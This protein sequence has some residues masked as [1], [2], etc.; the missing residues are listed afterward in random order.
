[1]LA[2]KKFFSPELTASRHWHYCQVRRGKR[3]NGKG[4]SCRC[5]TILVLVA[6]HSVEPRKVVYLRLGKWPRPA[7]RQLPVLLPDSRPVPSCAPPPP[8]WWSL[9]AQS[10]VPFRLSCFSDCNLCAVAPLQCTTSPR[11]RL[12][13]RRRRRRRRAAPTCRVFLSTAP[14]T[15]A[16]PRAGLQCQPG[17]PCTRTFPTDLGLLWLL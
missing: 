17:D 14:R 9:G 8:R 13:R 12:Q 16:R 2:S 4:C 3:L 5:C 6:M 7:L 11:A 15:W 10:H 1:M